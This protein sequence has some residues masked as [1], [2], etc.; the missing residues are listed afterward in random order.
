MPFPRNVKYVG[1]PMDNIKKLSLLGRLIRQYPTE[2]LATK[3]QLQA[4][5]SQAEEVQAQFKAKFLASRHES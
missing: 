2:W 4:A 3:A 5:Q 1:V